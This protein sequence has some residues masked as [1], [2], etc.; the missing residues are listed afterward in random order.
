MKIMWLCNTPLPELCGVLHIENKGTKE[1][2]LVGISN[3]MEENTDL[4]I[5]HHQDEPCLIC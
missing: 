2:W 3:E 4:G 1:G 5:Q